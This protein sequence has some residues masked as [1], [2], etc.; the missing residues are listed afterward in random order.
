MSASQ[1]KGVNLF[2]SPFYSQCSVQQMLET[3]EV[4]KK[5]FVK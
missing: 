2:S 5:T 1:G 4:I 3:M